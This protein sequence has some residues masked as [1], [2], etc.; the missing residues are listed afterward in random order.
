[1]R[2]KKDINKGIISWSN[3]K[4]SKLTSQK[5]YDRQYGELVIK[6]CELE[7][8]SM[9]KA[10]KFGSGPIKLSWIPNTHFESVNQF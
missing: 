5:L 6:S 10:G 8:N 7:V 9:C 1:M 3:T 2:I 4:F